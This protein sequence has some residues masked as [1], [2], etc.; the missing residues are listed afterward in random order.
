MPDARGVAGLIAP[1]PHLQV[2]QVQLSGAHGALN[3]VVCSHVP[4]PL[5]LVLLM[6]SPVS[7]TTADALGAQLARLLLFVHGPS[8]TWAALLA[9]NPAALDP[10]LSVAVPQLTAHTP[11]ALTLP[12]AVPY[13]HT[14]V[15]VRAALAEALSDVRTYVPPMEQRLLARHSFGPHM[16]ACLFHSGVLVATHMPPV[17]LSCVWALCN[18]HHLMARSEQHPRC[19]L[20]KDVW[21]PP[22]HATQPLQ[23]RALVRATS[24]PPFLRS[25]PISPPPAA[26]DGEL[27]VLEPTQMVVGLG[28]DLLCALLTPDGEAT[29]AH[30]EASVQLDAALAALTRLRHP[31]HDVHARL[32]AHVAADATA[33]PVP[34]LYASLRPPCSSPSLPLTSLQP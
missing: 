28:S 33:A 6:P 26:E 17:A 9:A 11:L 14:S 22:T 32:A 1:R 4:P 7:S 12:Y 15:E 23:R 16:D 18:A 10:L 31:S 30:L 29:A 5:L 27:S 24:V 19:V 20:L 34:P 2:K 25:A 13:C 3:A 8:A 21:L